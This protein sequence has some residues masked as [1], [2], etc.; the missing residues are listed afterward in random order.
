MERGPKSL[1]L[2]VGELN[3]LGP[4]FGFIGDELAEFAGCH[5][6]WRGTEVCKAR[7]YVGVGQPG[8]DLLI[9]L[10]NDVRGRAFW[11]PMPC[12]AFAS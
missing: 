6:H 5:E 3:D 1:W 11:R 12:D 10:I 2:D 7:F 8:V 9:E 4:L